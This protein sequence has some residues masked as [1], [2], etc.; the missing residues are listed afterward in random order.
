M[1]D[2]TEGRAGQI[3]VAFEEAIFDPVRGNGRAAFIGPAVIGAV[4]V[5]AA[6]GPGPGA[7]SFAAVLGGAEKG[8]MGAVI[9]FAFGVGVAPNAAHVVP[10]A[11]GDTFPE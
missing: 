9:F 1:G 7:I 3:R 4:A 10:S 11:R 6:E 8:A 5:A 2:A